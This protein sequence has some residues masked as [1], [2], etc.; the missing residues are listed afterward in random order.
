MTDKPAYFDKRQEFFRS[1]FEKGLSYPDYVSGA[2]EKHQKRWNSVKEALSLSSELKQKIDNFD[3]QMNVIVL[4]GIWCGD[5]ARQGPMLRTIEE[6]TDK[7]TF[8]YLDNRENPE[9][10]DELRILGAARVPVVLAMSEDF[11][12]IAR[13]GDRTLSA[14]RRKA[15]SELGPACDAG[16]VIPGQEELNVEL[17]EWVEFFERLELMLRLAP[18]LRK[19]YND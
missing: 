15:E 17:A 10:Q 18:M 8:R 2:E 7:I 14:Y 5:C 3:R 4:S 11:F 13:F 16:L 9:L 12:E 6:A 19:R 1:Y